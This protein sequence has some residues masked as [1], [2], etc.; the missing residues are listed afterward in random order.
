[1]GIP[2]EAVDLGGPRREFLRLLIEALLQSP[3]FEGDKDK[4]NLA[5]D[6]SAMREDRYFIAGRAIAVS[7][8]H[9]GPP[10][11]FLSPTLFSLLVDGPEL[12]KPVLEDIADRDLHEKIKKITESKSLEEYL[13][14]AGCLRPLRRLED[15]NQLGHPDVP[16]DTQNTHVNAYLKDSLLSTYLSPACLLTSVCSV[17]SVCVHNPSPVISSSSDFTDSYI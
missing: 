13:A 8:V 5:F 2:E 14:T 12:A 15:K 17:S 16:S 6:S 4:M 3:M 10:A 1:M 11:G 7:L 9:G